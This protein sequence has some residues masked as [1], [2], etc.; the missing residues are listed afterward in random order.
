MILFANAVDFPVVCSGSLA[1]GPGSKEK[2]QSKVFQLTWGFIKSPSQVGMYVAAAAALSEILLHFVSQCIGAAAAS[3]TKGVFD[4][5]LLLLFGWFGILAL[6][7]AFPMIAEGVFLL[8]FLLGCLYLWYFAVAT[9]FAAAAAFVDGFWKEVCMRAAAALFI[10]LVGMFS[11]VGAFSMSSV[12]KGLGFV[13]AQVSYFWKGVCMRA[14]AALFKALVYRFFGSGLL[15]FL[16]PGIL[17]GWHVLGLRIWRAARIVEVTMRARQSKPSLRCGHVLGLRMLLDV[18]SSLRAVTVLPLMAGSSRR[19]GFAAPNACDLGAIRL[20]VAERA[21]ASCDGVI[22]VVGFNDDHGVDMSVIALPRIKGMQSF[23]VD[24]GTRPHFALMAKAEATPRLDVGE[25]SKTLSVSRG[26]R[27]TRP[28]GYQVFVRV[29]G[30]TLVIQVW[31]D[32]LISDLRALVAC[33]LHASPDQC[34]VTKG[35]KLLSLMSSVREVGLVKGSM[36]ELHARGVGGGSVPGEWYCSHCQRGGCWPARSHCFRCGLPRSE[37]GS[38]KNGKAKGKGGTPPRETSYPGKSSPT[39][40]RAQAGKGWS[41]KPNGDNS[42]PVSLAPDVVSQLLNLLQNLG[43]SQQV[44]GEIRTKTSQ[45]SQKARVVPARTR[46]VAEMEEKWLKAA[47]HLENLRE[48]S[49]KKEQEY[50]ASLGRFEEQKKVVEKLEAEYRE[51]KTLLVTPVPSDHS[52]GGSADEKVDSDGGLVSDMEVQDVEDLGELHDL[53]LI[54]GDTCKGDPPPD[55]K[56]VRTEPPK[57]K[58]PPPIS[59]SPKADRDMLLAA[60]KSGVLSRDEIAE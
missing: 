9:L 60:I 54:S 53:D 21:R 22:G 58:A 11:L 14:A 59:P 38:G 29:D 18:A 31:E 56:R 47:S 52:D 57:T 35:G 24:A 49:T 15:S 8:L 19:C 42:I 2:S 36:V 20:L 16:F 10:A 27:Q 1:C 41:G 6:P 40:A 32:M 26:E 39:A 5:F 7:V 3:A 34:Y 28:A 48:Q 12:S 13:A 44:M 4:V 23:R 51:A 33:R 43:V 45:A 50:L 37:V 25:V 17:E 55:P 30:K 46:R